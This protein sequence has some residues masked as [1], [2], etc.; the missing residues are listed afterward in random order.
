MN[1]CGLN[2]PHIL[3]DFVGDIPEQEIKE[4]LAMFNFDKWY[5][6]IKDHL[7][8]PASYIFG[9]E[10][11]YNGNIDNLIETLPNKEC[12]A[13]LDS[14]STKPEKAYKNSTEIVTDI[15]RNSRTFNEIEITTKVIIREWI[16]GITNEFRCYVLDTKLRGIS[17][18]SF[19]HQ[20]MIMENI[21]IIEQSVSKI[22]KLT[23]NDDYSV[24]FGF[25]SESTLMMIEINSPVYLAATSGNFD[26]SVP[27]D[28]EILLGDYMV[29]IVS[30]PVI[31]SNEAAV[32]EDDVE[33]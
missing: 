8:T 24:D 1:S 5:P 3:S 7:R 22:T 2:I 20:T 27:G 29:D 23:E 14:C 11:L 19:K 31:K 6:Q 12:F 4:L 10:D 18:N 26:L 15:Y 17:C 16:Y 9:L 32:E 13:R 25:D 28:Y 21:K 30:Y 33:P